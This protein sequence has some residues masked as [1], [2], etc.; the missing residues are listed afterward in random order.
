MSERNAKSSYI[1]HM[2]IALRQALMSFRLWG[3]NDDGQ[4]ALYESSHTVALVR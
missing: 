2:D 1:G 4:A 3:V